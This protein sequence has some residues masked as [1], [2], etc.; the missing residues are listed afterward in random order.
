MYVWTHNNEVSHCC[1]LD[2]VFLCDTNFLQDALFPSAAWSV[3]ILEPGCTE[4]EGNIHHGREKW[5]FT[6]LNEEQDWVWTCKE[7]TADP[8]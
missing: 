4:E 2:S 3:T 7:E 6:T 1:L 5:L 8:E